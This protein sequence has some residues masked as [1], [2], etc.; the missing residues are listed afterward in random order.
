MAP[1]HTSEALGHFRVVDLTSRPSQLCARIFADF[2]AEVIK[3]EPRA[4]SGI[5]AIADMLK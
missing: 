2:G 1:T 3:V 4:G 5:E